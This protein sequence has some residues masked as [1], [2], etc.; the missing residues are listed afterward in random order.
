M[1]SQPQR[2][3]ISNILY[4]SIPWG[5]DNVKESS[6]SEKSACL[7]IS[8]FLLQIVEARCES[9]SVTVGERGQLS[10][11][12][13]TLAFVKWGVTQAD[14]ATSA[15]DK[16]QTDDKWSEARPIFGAQEHHDPSHTA[17]NIMSSFSTGDGRYPVQQY[18]RCTPQ[19]WNVFTAG[20]LWWCM[21]C[22]GYINYF[23]QSYR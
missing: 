9:D 12:R 22:S 7:W 23:E 11:Y 18:M 2:S 21:F 16:F 1:F 19:W 5:R 10:G 3:A 17:F 4:P 13:P 6:H 20:I 8:F 14:T 15:Q